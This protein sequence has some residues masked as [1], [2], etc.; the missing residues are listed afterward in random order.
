MIDKLI[1]MY[2]HL[3][4]SER[5]QFARLEMQIGDLFADKPDG[6]VHFAS[7]L[8]GFQRYLSS[9]DEDNRILADAFRHVSE[10]WT[11]TNLHDRAM[12]YRQ[13]AELLERDL[14]VCAFP[15]IIVL[16]G[17]SGVGK[18]TLIREL[19]EKFPHYG[20]AVSDTCRDR[21][22]NETSDDYTFLSKSEFNRR[23][24]NNEYIES[25]DTYASSWDDLHRLLNGRHP[26]L[27]YD[28]D[29]TGAIA[30]KARFPQATTLICLLPPTLHILE[31]RLRKRGTEDE[32]E[33]TRRLLAGKK[34][35]QDAWQHYD[36]FIV[37]ESRAETIFQ[38]EAILDSIPFRRSSYTESA[39]NR[40]LRD[41][42]AVYEHDS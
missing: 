25:N 33:I 24:D 23:R 15:N 11:E 14:P 6:Y 18:S 19:K 8:Y 27:V 21:R 4:P 40:Y 32:T 17:P 26:V 22:P 42:A 30:L 36:Y 3:S 29:P 16:S 1:S 9:S 41:F 13:Q 37:T 38:M 35:I 7:A 31:Q 20:Y 12:Q 5:L 34:L 28:L 39:V 2:E 10:M